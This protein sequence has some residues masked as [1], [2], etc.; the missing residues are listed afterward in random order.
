MAVGCVD[1]GRD[2]S[3]KR[4]RKEGR[5]WAMDEGRKRQRRAGGCE[6]D[7]GRRRECQKE[8]T[9]EG[10]EEKKSQVWPRPSQDSLKNKKSRE[11]RRRMATMAVHDH[12]GQGKK[13]KKRKKFVEKK[14]P[15]RI[16]GERARKHGKWK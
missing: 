3:R 4:T 7:P 13:R 10:E 11:V 9:K 16:N 15:D 6:H 12:D 14:R 1:I 2:N 8:A 5:R